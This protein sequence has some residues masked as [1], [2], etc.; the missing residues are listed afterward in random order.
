MSSNSLKTSHFKVYDLQTCTIIYVI[1]K[2]FHHPKRWSFPTPFSRSW[3]LPLP[4]IYCLCEF[5]VLAISCKW[6]HIVYDLLSLISFTYHVLLSH[7]CCVSTSYVWLSNIS[8]YSY[9][10]FYLTK[11]IF[12]LFPPFSYCAWWC[13]TFLNTCF[14]FFRL[15]IIVGPYRAILLN[16]LRSCQ[17]LLSLKLWLQ[18][19]T[20]PTA[21]EV[22]QYLHILTFF[23]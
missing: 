8:L 13:W 20:F 5:T 10:T 12:R 16:F 11:W 9:N 19:F 6:D 14:W 7:H 4:P 22:F 1:P 17:I 3:Y 18:Y 23:Y 15:Y 21:C 2:Y